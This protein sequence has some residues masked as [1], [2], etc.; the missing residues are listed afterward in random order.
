MQEDK[1]IRFS[2]FGSSEGQVFLRKPIE[3]VLR[4]QGSQF[5][6]YY[7]PLELKV[8]AVDEGNAIEAFEKALAELYQ[9]LVCHQGI[10]ASRKAT[11]LSNKL[12]SR[13]SSVDF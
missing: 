4:D 7:A 2:S 8:Q 1:Y 9:D 12:F 5:S 11:A 10:G 3:A 13:I 6:M